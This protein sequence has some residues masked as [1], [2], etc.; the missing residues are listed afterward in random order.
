VEDGD[1]NSP[2]DVGDLMGVADDD[3]EENMVDLP[4]L[5]VWGCNEGVI[6]K[7]KMTL[8]VDCLPRRSCMIP[9][10]EAVNETIDKTIKQ[11]SFSFLPRQTRKS[12][13]PNPETQRKAFF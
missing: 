7:S 11:E 6:K 8:N 5:G 9:S 2:P 4:S 1:N 3:D 12:P 13:P 10:I